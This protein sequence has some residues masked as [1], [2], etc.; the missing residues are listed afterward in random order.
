MTP[1]KG[2]SNLRRYLPKKPKKW[3]YKLWALAGISGCVCK[4]EL[5][6]GEGCSGPLPG[7]APPPRCGERDFVVMRIN[8]ELPPDRH[9]LFF[10]N[11]FSSLE[12]LSYLKKQGLWVFSTLNKK[13]SR[14][15]PIATHSELKRDGR[16]AM[17]EIPDSKNQLVVTSWFDNKSVL[18]LSNYVGI[19]LTYKCKRYDRKQKKNI[20]VDRP[21]ATVIYNKFMSGV[22]KAD[23]L[24]SVCCS[25]I[26]SKKWYHRLAFHIYSW[27]L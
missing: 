4:F 17:K 27:V 1:F 15:C 5:D 11:Y 10:D 7:I 14:D 3:G 13:R 21:A 12:L 22:D 25:K 24:L 20:D 9:F 23:M 26:R 16:G 2:K 19:N 8:H 6:G 18:M